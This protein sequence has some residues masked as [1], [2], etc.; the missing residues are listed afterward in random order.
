MGG[1]FGDAPVT[2]EVDVVGVPNRGE[3][4]GD[5]DDDGAVGDE[6]V[7]ARERLGLA[8]R[9][10]YQLSSVGPSWTAWLPPGT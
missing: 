9:A 10:I 2:E 1:M 5:Q 8:V 6:S 7:D 3:S 4:V